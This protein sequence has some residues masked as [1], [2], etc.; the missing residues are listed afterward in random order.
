MVSCSWWWV[1]Q[2]RNK[3]YCIPTDTIGTWKI[4]QIVRAAVARSLK[5][6]GL[7]DYSLANLNS[8]IF[9]LFFY[10]KI[11]AKTLSF[12]GSHLT[13]LR[14]AAREAWGCSESW[15]FFHTKYLLICFYPYLL[16]PWMQEAQAKV[17]IS[18]RKISSL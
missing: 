8:S 12:N 13:V 4:E 1:H 14:D 2:N 17:P 9:I 10:L 11:D 3:L 6:T 18:S 16:M 7:L 5:T 15:F